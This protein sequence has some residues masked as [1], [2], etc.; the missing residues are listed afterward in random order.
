MAKAGG[1][2][3]NTYV[4]D[5]VVFD[6]ETTGISPKTDEVVEIS[7]VK[8]EHGKVTD[9]FSTLVNPKRRIP[10]GA[11]RVNGITD[12]MVAEAPFFEQVLEEFL[13]FIEGFVL[14]GHNIARFDMN[15]LY[16]DVEKYFERSLPNDYIDTLQMARRELPNLEHHR[17]T[18]L[19]EYYGISAEGAHRALNDCRMNQQVFEKMGNPV[20][21]KQGKDKENNRGV[22]SAKTE[23]SE[24]AQNTAPTVRKNL[25]FAV[26]TPK[27]RYAAIRAYL[28]AHPGQGGIIYCLT[29]RNVEE[30][31]EKLIRDGFSVTRYHAGLSDAERQKNQDDFIYDRVP[32]MVATNAFGMG[33][34]RSDVRFVLHCGM[35]K[36]LEAYYQEAGRAG[37][38]GEPAEC[39]LYYSGRDVVTNQLFIERNQDN[40]E[41]DDYTRQL[42]LERDRER[43]KMTFYCFTNE[44]LRDYILRYFGEY[45]S[46]YCG[47]CSNCMTQFDTIDIQAA[48]ESLLGCV[49]SCGQRYGTTVILDTVHGANTVKIRNYRM[50][51][52]PHYGELAKESVVHLRQMFNFL[53]VEEYLFVTADEYSIVKLTEKGAAFLEAPEPIEMKMAKERE[54]QAAGSSKKSRRGAKLPAGAAEFTEKEETLFE[55]LRALRREI[56][57][58]EKVPPYIVFSDK[59][60]THMCILKPVTEA[61]MLEVSGVGAYKFEKYGE[62]FLECVRKFLES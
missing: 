3:L 48:A 52:N 25:Y 59:T 56:A 14:V 53:Q 16:R 27:D 40:Q 24:Q 51:E 1:N 13:E 36:N 41:L 5:Y 62:R 33:I 11:S 4:A 47:N 35:P 46:N 8:V 26:E 31:C 37:R 42:V 7:A 30:I 43:L 21:K 12:D 60:L 22:D 20:Y 32:V 19:A 39:I 38:D 45:G 18:D 28:E 15:F 2:L 9:E 34:D 49:Q 6:L 55:A 54:K 10:Y 23:P 58:E 57:S 44:C 50:N 17:L 61:E 29:R